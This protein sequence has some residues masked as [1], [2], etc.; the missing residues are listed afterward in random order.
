MTKSEKDLLNEAAEKYN[1]TIHYRSTLYIYDGDRLIWHVD[2]YEKN[3][4]LF[5]DICLFLAGYR[6][7]M[8][9]AKFAMYSKIDEIIF[10][11]QEKEVLKGDT[12]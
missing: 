10:G 12:I 1:L 2:N 5:S 7:G 3:E 11:T 4:R 6:A 9:H 8:R